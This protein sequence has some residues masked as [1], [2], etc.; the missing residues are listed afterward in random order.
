MKGYMRLHERDGVKTLGPEP[1]T[2]ANALADSQLRFMGA[3]RVTKPHGSSNTSSHS[4]PPCGG[5]PGMLHPL[6]VASHVLPPCRELS[7]GAELRE[8][9]LA[10]RLSVSQ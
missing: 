3:L 8:R 4:P 2:K 5:G 9:D 7:R 10:G 6:H 1:N